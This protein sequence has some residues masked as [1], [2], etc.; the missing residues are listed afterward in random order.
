M[1]EY[2]PEVVWV[3]DGVVTIPPFW[4]DVPTAGKGVGFRS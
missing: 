4:V 1:S 3:D 2:R